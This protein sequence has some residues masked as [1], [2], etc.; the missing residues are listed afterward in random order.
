MARNTFI[1]LALAAMLMVSLAGCVTA[2]AKLGDDAPIRHVVL[3]AFKADIT[4][5]QRKVVEA[6]SAD[7][8]HG[9]GLIRHYEWGTDLNAGQRSQGYTHCIVMT[10]DD[11][12]DLKEYIVHP[13]HVAFK[14][15]RC[16]SSK[17]YSCW[18]FSPN[19]SRARPRRHSAGKK[20]APWPESDSTLMT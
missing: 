8:V 9:T 17:R 11:A 4:D 7:L 3:L 20:G 16:P 19:P 1:Q 18:T 5:E 12:A 2:K 14:E 15:R 13:A 10:F 6:A